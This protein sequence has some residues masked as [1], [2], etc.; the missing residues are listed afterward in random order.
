[1]DWIEMANDSVGCF[2]RPGICWKYE[3]FR[4]SQQECCFMEV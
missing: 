3:R 2:T 1:V 4:A